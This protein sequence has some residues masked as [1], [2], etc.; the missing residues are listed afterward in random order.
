ML[1][2]WVMTCLGVGMLLAVALGQG[3]APAKPTTYRPLP[4]VLA[5]VVKVDASAH[6]ITLKGTYRGK[7]QEWTLKVAS[8]SKMMK[9]GKDAKLTDFKEGEQVLVS[10]K[11]GMKEIRALADPVTFFAFLRYPTLKGKVK[12]FDA[13]TLT[14]TV[15]AEGKEHKVT[16]PGR[17]VCCFVGGKGHKGKEAALKGGEEVVI[18]LRT[19]DSARAVFDAASWK[20][21]G[22]QEWQAYQKRT[23][24]KKGA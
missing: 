20:V 5:T 14:L 6:T 4:H 9:D 21:Y 2:S 11:P 7:E 3:K 1:R 19:P 18:V 16:L 12:A 23:G 15:E 13:A 24:A 17:G 8:D 10:W 22:E